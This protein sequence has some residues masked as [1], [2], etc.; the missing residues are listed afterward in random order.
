MTVCGLTSIGEEL[1][2]HEHIIDTPNGRYRY[3]AEYDC[4]YRVYESGDL[5]HLSQF[6]W[7]Y[8]CAV[9]T[10]ICFYVTLVK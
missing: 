6:G 2:D 5:T 10:A 8:V 9:L 4:Y 3:D 7:I 1:M